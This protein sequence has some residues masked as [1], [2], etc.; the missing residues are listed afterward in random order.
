MLHSLY[1]LYQTSHALVSICIEHMQL[2]IYAAGNY[3]KSDDCSCLALLF[4][5]CILLGIR[6][7][8]LR[9][10]R[11]IFEQSSYHQ[12]EGELKKKKKKKHKSGS[13]I[14]WSFISLFNGLKTA[15]G[16]PIKLLDQEIV[17]PS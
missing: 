11:L 7:F 5:S 15:T 6:W 4:S 16:W 12:I 2:I 8:R 9:K 17:Q 3:W 1:V 10:R 13:L 14:V